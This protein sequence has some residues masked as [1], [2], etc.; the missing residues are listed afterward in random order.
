MFKSYV[1]HSKK[2]PDEIFTLARYLATD[3]IPHD[4]ISTLI[5]CRLLPVNKN[6]SVMTCNRNKAQFALIENT[7][8]TV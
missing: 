7:L 2:L 5:A 4:H 6:V 3:I 1:T 8:D